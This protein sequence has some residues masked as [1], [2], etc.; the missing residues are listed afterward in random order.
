MEWETLFA[1]LAVGEWPAT[2]DERTVL[3]P[4]L[5]VASAI[6][7]TATREISCVGRP[8]CSAAIVSDKALA[9]GETVCFG[10]HSPAASA[11]PLTK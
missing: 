1:A 7:L 4:P 9:V 2:V 10:I 5:P 11:V 3:Y 8:E 6:P